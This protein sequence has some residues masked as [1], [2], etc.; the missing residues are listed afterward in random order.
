MMPPFPLCGAPTTNIKKEIKDIAKKQTA[1]LCHTAVCPQTGSYQPIRKGAKVFQSVS[2]KLKQPRS[3]TPF[4]K[5]SFSL[6][7]LYI[8]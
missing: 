6:Q 2:P 4:G 5:R 1:A 7:L 8:T 3:R